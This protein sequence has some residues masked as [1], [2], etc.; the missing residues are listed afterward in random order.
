MRSLAKNC[1][2]TFNVYIAQ[3]LSR[4]NATLV[5]KPTPHKPIY[6]RLRPITNT[7]T[8]RLGGQV[9]RRLSRKQK[10]RGSNPR[11][12]CSLHTVL[13]LPCKYDLYSGEVP[14]S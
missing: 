4:C 14:S 6:D 9:V 3:V 7:K 12:A 1:I 10:I 11:R 13:L 2:F 8:V 5:G